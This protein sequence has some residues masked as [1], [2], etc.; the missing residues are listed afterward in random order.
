MTILNKVSNRTLMPG[1][2]PI[3]DVP[4]APTIG[5]ASVTSTTVVSVP[6]TAAATGGTPTTYTVT[7]TPGSF[8]GTGA[9][10]PITVTAAYVSNTSYTFKVKGVNATAT[11][12]ESSASNSVSPLAD[13]LYFGYDMG[14][15]TAGGNQTSIRKFNFQSESLTTISETLTQAQGSVA[16]GCTY[17][18]NYGYKIGGTGADTTV[19]SYAT[20][21]AYANDTKTNITSTPQ[22]R[23]Y[24]ASISNP[25]TAGYIWAGETGVPSLTY[26]SSGLKLTYAGDTYS[27][28]TNGTA[29]NTNSPAGANNGTSTGYRIGGDTTGLGKINFSNDSYS[30]ASNA[31]IDRQ[32]TSASSYATTAAYAWGGMQNNGTKLSSIAKLTFSNDGYSTISGTLSSGRY[33]VG[34][35]SDSSTNGY[36]LGGSDGTN[37]V[38]TIQK[39]VYS[40]ETVSTSSTALGTGKSNFATASNYA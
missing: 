27:T 15:N 14:G 11:G 32:Y 34:Q 21:I 36:A 31:S 40:T 28:Q 33:I 37:N 25:S 12:P 1:I 35:M 3:P 26:Y 16:G 6:F 23:A 38:T 7:S 24:G 8:T 20:K 18:G 2:T 29:S 13:G 22:N 5:T 19:Y 10:S 39:I 9:S 4:D 30:Y 17:K